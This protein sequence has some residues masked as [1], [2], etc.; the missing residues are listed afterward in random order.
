[1]GMILANGAL[2][3]SPHLSTDKVCRLRRL[4]G[5][6]EFI[7]RT[8]TARKKTRNLGTLGAKF[9]P[10][11]YRNPCWLRNA[12]LLGM[13]LGSYTKGLP[14]PSAPARR[15]LPQLFHGRLKIYA[16]KVYAT[17]RYS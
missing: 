8:Q 6:C 4:C 2:R 14:G 10:A 16:L 17:Q 1:M 15:T 5:I 13:V 12:G 3:T 7:A 11:A 9:D